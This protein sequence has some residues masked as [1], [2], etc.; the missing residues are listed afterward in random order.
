M[1][2]DVVDFLFYE[3][4]DTFL[5]GLQAWCQLQYTPFL[6][7]IFAQLIRPP[8]FQ[9]TLKSTRISFKVYKPPQEVDPYPTSWVLGHR[10]HQILAE[11]LA[12]EH[13][14]DVAIH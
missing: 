3:I 12:I 7:H 14:E 8:Q 2:F 4:E 1:I 10:G 5:D 13:E 9:Q 6:S 11:D